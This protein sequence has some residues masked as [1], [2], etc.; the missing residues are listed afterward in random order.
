MKSQKLVHIISSLK[1]GG[2]ESLLVDLLAELS[3]YEHHVIYFYDGPNRER[4]EAM[5][6]KTYQV[7]GLLSLYDPI[8]FLR[9]WSLVKRLQPDCIHSS[10]WAAN[11]AARIIARFHHVPLISVLHWSIFRDGTLR[12]ILD[13]FTFQLAQKVVGVSQDIAESLK[14]SGWISERNVFTIP[15]G[16]SVKRI[17][18]LAEREQV[19]RLNLGLEPDV[20]V[21]GFVG[22]FVEI[23]NIPL[24]INAFA[25][26]LKK[27]KKIALV[28]L[29]FGPLE[30][31]LRSL[32]RQLNIEDK[33]RFIVGQAAY[34]YYHLFDCF[35]LPSF[36]EGMSVALL[37]AMCFSLPCIVTSSTRYHE[38][39]RSEE[40]GFVISSNDEAA[41]VDKLEVL[42]EDPQLRKRIGKKAFESI[43]HEFTMTAM[44]NKY[45]QIFESL[46]SGK[47]LH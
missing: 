15:N 46:L 43:N 41:L 8:F 11:F 7:K 24:L 37:E 28:L 21:I 32:V 26:I 19:T 10:L 34:G 27:N 22:R 47:R 14:R 44:T 5:N 16:I 17:R 20:F 42:M 33:V 38:V 45:I 12:N 36:Q 30:E 6:I 23:K 13:S 1:R 9:L 3:D 18:A 35:V 29:G 31:K 4:L 25:E 40:N 39:I 2:A